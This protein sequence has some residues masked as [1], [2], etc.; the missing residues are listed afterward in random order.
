ME[1]STLDF[2]KDVI[3]A[4]KRIPVVVDF[5]A[6]WCGPCKMLGPMLEKLASDAGN[7]WRLVKV[8][9]DEHPQLSSEYGIRGIPAVKMFY[10]GSVSA[11]FVGALPEAQV[12]KWSL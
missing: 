5:W 1:T 3:E 9:T 8:N 7:T 10:N 12:K 4:S 11:E 2:Q 6:E